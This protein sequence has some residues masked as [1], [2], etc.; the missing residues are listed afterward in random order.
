[1]KQNK[2]M[3]VVGLIVLF[4]MILSACQ[5]VVT[6]VTV[7]VT[8]VVTQKETQIVNQVQTQVVVQEKTSIVTVDRKPFTTPH[9][10]LGNLKVRQAIAYC[11]NKVDLIKSVY[12][13]L[14]A[15]DQ[16][17]LVLNSFIESTHW[18][19]AG[20][21]NLT[22]YPFQKDVGASMLQDAGWKMDESTGF[23]ANAA[24][25][26]L[27]LKF[28]TTNAVFRQTWSAVFENQMK[29]CGI[30]IV[31]FMVPSSWWFG[32]STGIARRDFE[33]GAFA[34]VGQADPGGQTLYACDQIPLPSN[35]WSGQNDMG[36]CNEKASTA[37][38]K[39]NNTLVQ[40]DRKAN[41]TIV[42]QEYS[43]DVPAIP[44]FN[45]T[46]TYAF[47]P[48]LTGFK[49]ASG[50]QYWTW[51]VGEW[52]IEG[53]DTIVIGLTQEPSTLYTLINSASVAQQSMQPVTGQPT[54]SL[55]NTYTAYHYYKTLPTIE[56]GGAF[57]NDV[58]VKEGD[59]IMDA[60]GNPVALKDGVKYN[61]NTGAVQTYKAGTTVKMKQI[62]A[63]YKLDSGI[64]WSDGKPLVKADLELSW[65]VTCDKESGAISFI[66]C[67]QTAKL[68]FK[69]DT[70]YTWTYKPGFQYP[71]Y[72]ATTAGWLP[73][74]LVITT[75][76]PYKGK[77]L[78]QVPAKDMASLK[79]IAEKPMDVGPY[80]I[81]EWKKGQS[82]SYVA[83]PNWYGTPVK[84]KNLVIKFIEPANA[85]AQLIAGEVDIL[86]D[87]ALTAKTE[88][89]DKAE[90]AGKV[91]V[92]VIPSAT[93][94]HI[95]FSLFIK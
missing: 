20:D 18:A 38:K 82:I 32:D 33:L 26:P 70:E 42:Q 77:T 48:K 28:T 3:L 22:I 83:N 64:K 49:Q 95:D 45:R 71:L 79:E 60:D 68:E 63:N 84:T 65:K 50:N 56:N 30:Q 53:K 37:I 35:G 25:D 81:K 23:R 29:A 76:G 34:W 24:G 89:L 66:T 52:A 75:E 87:E 44:L 80:M 19:Y 7:E 21:A 94:E 16:K 27:S 57:N 67:D 58:D 62:V 59:Q 55:D 14:T 43:K 13:L 90:K 17:K 10:I 12:P 86:G 88:T 31:R 74:H 6:T 72:F 36:W 39:A 11:T 9:P 1:M 2:V 78:D 8:K 47:N 54:P 92:L 5:P 51:N 93:L 91:K 69:S 40:A 46:N 73:A 85:E 15:E 61:D 4:S 41:F